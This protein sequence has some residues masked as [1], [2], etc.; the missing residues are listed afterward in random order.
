L[1]ESAN[2][3]QQ[4]GH[5]GISFRVL[6]FTFRETS[7]SASNKETTQSPPWE[8]NRGSPISTSAILNSQE[9]KESDK[10]QHRGHHLLEQTWLR[11]QNHFHVRGELLV[12]MRGETTN[13]KHSS[14][15]LGF[16]KVKQAAALNKKVHPY[17]CIESS[18]S[19]CSWQ[20]NERLAEYI[21]ENGKSPAGLRVK[22]LG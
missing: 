10:V 22:C 7:T 1:T 8:L 13:R 18:R 16:K 15:A 3:P 14:W 9:H 21:E 4:A 12:G 19:S 5:S 20:I 11:R 17:S 6:N 2:I